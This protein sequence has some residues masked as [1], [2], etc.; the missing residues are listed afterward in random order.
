MS[1]NSG[2][3]LTSTYCDYLPN[4]LNEVFHGFPVNFEADLKTEE[5]EAERLVQKLDSCSAAG[6]KPENLLSAKDAR[7]LLNCASL[8]LCGKRVD[9][10][11]VNPSPLRLSRSIVPSP[12]FRL[13][14][15]RCCASESDQV[16]RL[17]G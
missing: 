15:G 2:A 16:A 8:C 17:G 1:A 4:L 12:G 10:K 5:E 11:N 13:C 3:E 7:L 6:D 14:C 9:R